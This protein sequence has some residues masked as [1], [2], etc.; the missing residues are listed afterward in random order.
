MRYH[1]LPRFIQYELTYACNS[2]CTFCYNP[3]HGKQPDEQICE[4]VLDI[5][6]YYRLHHVQL[7]GGE[8]TLLPALPTYLER[9]KDIRWRS[10]VTNGRIYVPELVGRVNEI[11]LSLHGTAEIHETLTQAKGSFDIIQDTIKKYV[12]GGIVVHSDTALTKVNAHLIYEIA[13]HAATLGMK[14]LFVNIFQSTGIGSYSSADLAPSI[15]Q[16]RD[17]ITQMLRARDEVGIDVQ[18]GTS[19]PFCLDERLV[20]EGLAFR[21]G[22][23]DWFAS[24]DPWG[25]FR[26]CNQSARSYGNVLDKPL[27]EIWHSY[28]INKEYR[29]L[30]W[31]GD[32]C[33]SCVFQC[34]CLGGCRI[35]GTGKPRVDPIVVRD[36]DYLISQERLK[37]LKAIFLK[38]KY[39]Q[40][41]G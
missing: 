37:E 24:I 27:H 28:P 11:F 14:T 6:N 17:A 22:T 2:A 5:L 29:N 26:I 15:F 35:E 16:I 13:V 3:N 4:A 19:T 12:S 36:K 10:I 21:C 40:P 18:F 8:I 7:I 1:V 32:P 31:I 34:E 25:E 20:T 33:Y 30:G 9:L 38:M 23:G 39:A 41:Y